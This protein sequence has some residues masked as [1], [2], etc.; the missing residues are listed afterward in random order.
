MTTAIA[1]ICKPFSVFGSDVT[2]RQIADAIDLLA[3]ARTEF[4]GMDL[5][6]ALL[7]GSTF[8]AKQEASNR[9]LQRWRKLG[10]I[11][12]KRGRWSLATGA[13][14]D[15]QLAASRARFQI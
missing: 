12:F 3:D 1:H 2:A 7:P 9:L 10:L 5:C 4:I 13:W 8:H 11:R 6:P 15:L 14:D